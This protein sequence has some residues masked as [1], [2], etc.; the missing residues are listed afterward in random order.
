MNFEENKKYILAAI[1]IIVIIIV[2]VAMSSTAEKA[3]DTPMVAYSTSPTSTSF[4]KEPTSMVVFWE[5]C[6]YLGKSVKFGPGTY[7]SLDNLGIANDS[8]SSLQVPAG[9]S[10]KLFEHGASGGQ[11]VTISSDTPC[12]VNAGFNDKMS[13]FVVT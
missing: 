5:H 1:I 8:L 2:I 4:I 11:S 12:L 7:G 9:R 3:L 10:V 13:S 6:N